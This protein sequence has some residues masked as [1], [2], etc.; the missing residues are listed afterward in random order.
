MSVEWE[1]TLLVPPGHRERPVQAKQKRLQDGRQASATAVGA[2]VAVGAAL[3]AA[4]AE[5]PTWW[6]HACLDAR[7]V[8]VGP[9][10]P[11]EHVSYTPSPVAALMR[12]RVCFQPAA[13]RAS[14]F[15]CGDW[16]HV[17]NNTCSE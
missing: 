4:A 16:A 13:L 1:G 6:R 15:Q 7:A 3:A 10:L 12:A 5:E 8:A 11:C 17:T 9:P 2:Q 14:L